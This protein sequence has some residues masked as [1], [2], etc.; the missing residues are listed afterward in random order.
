ME[1][2]LNG[3]RFFCR[4]WAFQETIISDI[5]TKIMLVVFIFERFMFWTIQDYCFRLRLD[6]IRF[7]DAKN[8]EIRHL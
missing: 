2:L 6:K 1:S 7:L 8:M 5:M 3:K 4:E